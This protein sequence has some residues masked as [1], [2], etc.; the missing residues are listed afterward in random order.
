MAK[1]DE[2]EKPDMAWRLIGA[3]VALGVGYATRKV[4]EIGWQKTTG[5]KPPADPNSLETSLAEAVGFAVVLGVGMEVARIVVT[6]SAH[7]RYRAWKA[8]PEKAERVVRS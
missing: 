4:I 6:R 3:V 1:S 8:I 2:V 7:K 5:K